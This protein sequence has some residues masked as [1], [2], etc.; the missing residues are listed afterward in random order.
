MDSYATYVK[1]GRMVAIVV[2]CWVLSLLIGLSPMMGWNRLKHYVET[3][4]HTLPVKYPS[5][6]AALVLI[7]RDVPYGGFLSK[8]YVSERREFNYSEIHSGH[9]GLCSF[10]TVFSP[11]YLVYFVFFVC[12]LLPL[13]AMLAIY[14]DLF[15]VIRGH[16]KSQALWPAKRGELQMAQTLFLLVGIF[17]MCWGPL[18]IIYSV[19]LLCP[20]CQSYD[21]LDRLAVLL[22]HLNS[23]AN[24]LV[25]AMRKKDFGQAFRSVFL[26]HVLRWSRF[27]GCCCPNPKVHPQNVK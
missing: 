9:V 27:R 5:E 13:V 10:T 3:N 8:I 12:T 15:R 2:S 16:F 26:H 23:L 4:N 21:S 20:K 19:R 17:C 14:V 6:R 18:H 1:K 25:Y 7:A 11:D 24:P 22:S